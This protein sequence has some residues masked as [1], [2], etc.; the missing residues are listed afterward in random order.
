MF[1]LRNPYVDTSKPT[2]MGAMVCMTMVPVVVP[3]PLV[4][5]VVDVLDILIIVY[6]FFVCEDL[7]YNTINSQSSFF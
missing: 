1:E 7:L 2:D 5:I 4:V 6:D 3:I